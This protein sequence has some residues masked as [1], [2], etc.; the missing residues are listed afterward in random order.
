[1][2]LTT[3]KKDNNQHMCSGRGGGRVRRQRR[4]RTMAGERWGAMVE[5]EEGL[6]CGGGGE[7]A[8]Q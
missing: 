7:T 5:V 3:T 8:L 6:L 2:A 1:M 4:R